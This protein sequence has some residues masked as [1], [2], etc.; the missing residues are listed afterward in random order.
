MPVRHS[1]GDGGYPHAAPRHTAGGQAYLYG[2]CVLPLDAIWWPAIVAMR[3]NPLLAHFARG[4]RE[5]G[6]P[7][8][9]IIAAVCGKLLHIAFG[10]LEH[11]RPFDPNYSPSP[12]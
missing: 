1:L 8:K 11:R 10:V 3:H 2:F 12:S 9:L 4:L 5:A 7:S 6:K